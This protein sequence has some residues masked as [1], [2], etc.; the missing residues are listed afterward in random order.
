[1]STREKIDEKVDIIGLDCYYRKVNKAKKFVGFLYLLSPLVIP[2]LI[3][4]L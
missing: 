1:M 3:N 4:P 2:S